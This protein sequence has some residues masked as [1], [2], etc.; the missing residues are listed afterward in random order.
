MTVIGTILTI[1]NWYSALY[2][3]RFYFQA[4]IIGPLAMVF[5]I[6]ATLFPHRIVPITTKNSG[7]RPTKFTQ[8]VLTVA[9]MSGL[10][11][12]FLLLLGK[13]PFSK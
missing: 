12:L 1:V 5:G 3:G 2:T 8:V 7:L 13:I 9:L 11:N 6:S 4:A 10:I